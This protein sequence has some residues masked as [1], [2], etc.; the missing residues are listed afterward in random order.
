GP[1]RPQRGPLHYSDRLLERMLRAIAICGVEDGASAT[2]MD[3]RGIR[4]HE[5]T[6]G[7]SRRTFEQ[8]TEWTQEA[9]KVR[10]F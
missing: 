1:W 8:L 2:C 6:E 10:V 7:I 3:A 9:D 5:L 4:D